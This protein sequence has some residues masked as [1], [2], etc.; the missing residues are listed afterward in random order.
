MRLFLRLVVL[1]LGLFA[2]ATAALAGSALAASG[3][4]TGYYVFKDMRAFRLWRSSVQV[5]RRPLEGW[6][7]F[8]PGQRP[9]LG[10]G[11]TR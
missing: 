5:R 11:R 9:F 7:P 8:V 3:D 10:G 1:V 4:V 6:V 2:I